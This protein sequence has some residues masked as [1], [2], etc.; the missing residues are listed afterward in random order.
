MLIFMQY[1]TRI[2]RLTYVQMVR[3]TIRATDDSVAPVLLKLME[4]RLAAGTDAKE[5][6]IALNRDHLHIDS[7]VLTFAN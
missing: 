6:R 7:D 4:D 2:M 1:G 5:E 3:V